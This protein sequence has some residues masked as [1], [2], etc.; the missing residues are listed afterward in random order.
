MED[1]DLNLHLLVAYVKGEGWRYMTA[2][3]GLEALET[4][5]MYPGIFAG[6]GKLLSPGNS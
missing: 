2:K 1:N 4:Y 5:K 3:N 6:M